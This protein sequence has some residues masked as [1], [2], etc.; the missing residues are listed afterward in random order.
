MKAYFKVK[1]GTIV[2]ALIDISV[3]NNRK[4]I[5]IHAYN[6]KG[7]ETARMNMIQKYNNEY[8]IADIYCNSMYRGNGIATKMLKIV[9]TLIDPNS[10]ITGTFV[11]YQDKM[12]KYKN[13]D[14]NKLFSDVRDFYTSN[15]YE[16]Y[17]SNGT[18][19]LKKHI[20]SI[21]FRKFIIKN[22]Y[23]FFF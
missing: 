7:F 19:K 13:V 14:Y 11:P 2:G 22:F 5:N 21:N 1:N 3:Y 10:I 20:A 18:I 23:F 12:D 17:K 6:E 8:Y 15:G 16:F 9:E 4:S